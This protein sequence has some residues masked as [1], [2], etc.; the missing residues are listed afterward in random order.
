[1]TVTQVELQRNKAE[2]ALSRARQ[3]HGTTGR[4]GAPVDMSAMIP[5]LERRLA[6][7]DALL[8]FA[9]IN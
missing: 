4:G 7:W 2:S 8:K 6:D 5:R 1:M 3:L 9:R